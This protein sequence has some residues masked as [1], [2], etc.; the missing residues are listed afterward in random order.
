MITDQTPKP[1]TR[2]YMVPFW[3]SDRMGTDTVST[4]E[5]MLVASV[6]SFRACSGY[7]VDL[8]VVDCLGTLSA[9]TRQKLLR[10]M[11][12]I[13][14]GK[15]LAE[16]SPLTLAG[17]DIP[18]EGG[19]CFNKLLCELHSPF[20]RTA[21]FDAD[22]IWTGPAIEVFDATW[23][24]DVA[25]VLCPNYSRH[26]SSEP[27]SC[28]CLT[29]SS[30]EAILRIMTTRERVVNRNSD[31]QL[32]DCAVAEGLVTRDNLPP[33]WAFDGRALFGTGPGPFH[34]WNLLANWSRGQRWP[35]FPA[36]LWTVDGVAIRAFH[37]SG[38]VRRAFKDPRVLEY[39][40]AVNG[41]I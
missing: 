21:L 4:Y 39:L 1:Q 26:G 7:D 34:N 25:G 31:E 32:I 2:G 23:T 14:T 3:P 20:D 6:A 10:L 24:A 18:W 40:A 37:I 15:V 16:E 30:R 36:G 13:W 29:V 28:A 27:G 17:A 9:P 5:K 22:L 33:E 38:I 11:A 12:R 8:L 35:G 41:L 19:C